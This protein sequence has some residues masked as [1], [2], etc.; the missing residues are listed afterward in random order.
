MGGLSASVLQLPHG[1][2]LDLDSF[3][4]EMPEIRKIDYG[5][6]ERAN[7][8][9]VST[10]ESSYNLIGIFIIICNCIHLIPL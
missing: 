5:G 7:W 2:G 8:L 1:I 9:K 10:N 4:A 3:L 6:V